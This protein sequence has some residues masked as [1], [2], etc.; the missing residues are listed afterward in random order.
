EECCIIDNEPIE[1]EEVKK[2]QTKLT[3]LPNSH[4]RKFHYKGPGT[5]VISQLPEEKLAQLESEGKIKNRVRLQPRENVKAPFPTNWQQIGAL[6]CRLWTPEARMP[7]LVQDGYLLYT[8]QDVNL[9]GSTIVPT[10]IDLNLPPNT[11]GLV[12]ACNPNATY[13]VNMLYVS[14]EQRIGVHVIAPFPE[15]LHPGEPIAKL[16]LLPAIT[17]VPEMVAAGQKIQDKPS[18]FLKT[19]TPDQDQVIEDL[20]KQYEDIF[21]ED[22]MQLGQTTAAIHRIDTKP[23]GVAYSKRYRQSWENEDFIGKE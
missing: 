6:Q 17:P 1:W 15:I 10:G 12:T 5:Q 11:I 18:P 16:I 19:L 3:R 8:N 21:A 14:S 23:D 7:K 13:V 9:Q 4:E 20:L 2:M 22:L